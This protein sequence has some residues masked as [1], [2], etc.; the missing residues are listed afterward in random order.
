MGAHSCRPKSLCRSKE[1][2]NVDCYVKGKKNGATRRMPVD[3]ADAADR[4]AVDAVE[5]TQEL[6]PN[7][8]DRA[9]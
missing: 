3:R 5:R 9:G 8:A 6:G 4:A 7:H 2:L 1:P